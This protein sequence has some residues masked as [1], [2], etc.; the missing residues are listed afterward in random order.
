MA[1]PLAPLPKNL[2]DFKAAQHLLSRAGFGGSPAAIRAMVDLGIDGAMSR[3]LPSRPT[4]PTLSQL[5]RQFRSDILRTETSAERMTRQRAMSSGDQ[6]TLKRIKDA[7]HAAIQQDDQQFPRVQDWWMRRIAVEA[8]NPFEEKMVLFWHGHF[9]SNW[10]KTRNSWHLVQQMD[11]FRREHVGRFDRLLR[12]ILR[13]P[14]MLAYLDGS[15]NRRA[16]P[17]EN[18]AREVLEL[19]TMGEGSGYTERDIKEGARALT[20]WFYN[21]NTPSLDAQHFDAGLKTIFGQTGPFGLDEFASLI[22][23]RPEPSR[24]L[25]RKLYRYFVNDSTEPGPESDAFITALAADLM[26]NKLQLRPSIVKMFRSAHFYSSANRLAVVRS[27][28]QLIAHATRSLGAPLR[29]LRTLKGFCDL[30]GQTLLE[31]PSVK[32]WDGGRTWCSAATLM[33]RQNASLYMFTG[34]RSWADR[35]PVAD[36]Y[37]PSR[38]LAELLPESAQPPIRDAVRALTE[39]VLAAPPD[40]ARLSILVRHVESSG[41]V[42]DDATVK[43]LLCLIC[44]FPEYQLC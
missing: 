14:A 30:M 20:G 2:F 37:R 38:L 36:E 24:F 16:M 19:F 39:F 6:A 4:G 34:M 11:L 3:L 1:D 17:N 26:R 15:S 31:P 41:G 25:A 5:S 40:D 12:G 23:Q 28:I 35:K 29:D 18:I 43:G 22:L 27:P 33:A 13:D 32:G 9:P 21:N 10:R 8:V 44:T 42:L 7:A